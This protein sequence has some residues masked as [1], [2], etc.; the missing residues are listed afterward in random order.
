MPLPKPVL[1]NRNFDQ[2]V[3]EG[4]ALIPRLAPTWTDHNASDPGITLVELFAWLTEMDLFRLDRISDE[5]LRGFLRLVGDAPR[6]ATPAET[7]LLLSSATELDLPAGLQ[8]GSESGTPLFQTAQAIDV[9]PAILADLRRAD[10]QSVWAANARASGYLP[11]GDDP[12]PGDAFHL[13]FDR[14]L[15]SAGRRLNLWL[16]TETHP[17]DAETRRRLLAEQERAIAAGIAGAACAPDAEQPWRHH[18]VRLRWEYHAGGGT[19]KALVDV[20]DETRALTLSGPVSVLIPADHVAGGPEP[21]RFWLRATWVS[22]RPECLPRVLRIGSNAVRATH[23]VDRLPVTL[24]VSQGRADLHVD[25]PFR[26]VVPG[27]CRM[28]C[29]LSGVPEGDWQEVASFDQSGAH[30][31]HFTLDA[32]RGRIGFGNGRRGRVP[33]AAANLSLA[34]RTGGGVAGNVAAHRLERWSDGVHNETLFPGWSATAPGVFLEQPFAAADGADGESLRMAIARVVGGLRQPSRAT[35]L[36]DFE[37]FALSVPGVPVARARALPDRHPAFPCYRAAGNITIVVVPACP[38]PRP[39]PSPGMC[40]AVMR[41]LE[42]RRIPATELHVVAPT[43]ASVRVVATV[44]AD[45]G[46]SPPVLREVILAALQRFL[47]PLHGGEDGLGWPVGRDV[48]RSEIL[49]LLARIRGVSCVQYMGLQGESDAEPRC[50]NLPVCDDSL[51]ASGDHAIQVLGA[52]PIRLVDRS[53]S[54][55]CP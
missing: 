42:T 44:S 28:A 37:Y 50:A 3:A 43:Y 9:S 24:A 33:P 52:T 14:P 48:Y 53:A 6:L 2:L 10:G 17:A 30:D 1:D 49:A 25:L 39:T 8:M 15:G 32:A 35:T 34:C 26:P 40:A 20:I 51:V 29:D 55:E 18:E 11:F 13:G 22:G 23:V 19:W 38:G 21:T 12:K 31:E 27:S 47:H 7:T 45:D 16:W 5:Q 41:Y 36:A 54:H 4:R 46:V